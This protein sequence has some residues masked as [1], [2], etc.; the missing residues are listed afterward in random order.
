MPDCPICDEHY[1][2]GD[3]DTMNPNAYP[4]TCP[5]RWLV[6]N[7]VQDTE[8]DACSIYARSAAEAAERWAENFDR[9]GTGYPIMAGMKVVLHVRK[10]P[11]GFLQRFK[12]TGEAEPVYTAEELK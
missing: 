5:P 4:H 3:P 6:W 12:V 2:P 7:E 1:I 9:D 8:A 10:D 11:D